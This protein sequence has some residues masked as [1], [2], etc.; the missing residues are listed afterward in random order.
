M[1][2]SFLTSL[3]SLF[4]VMLVQAQVTE[5]EVTVT[6]EE[7]ASAVLNAIGGNDAAATITKLKVSG[8]INSYDFMIMRNKMP[9]LSELDLGDARVVYNAY[10]HYENYHSEND[11]FPAYAF[12]RCKNLTK[13]VLPRNIT[14]IGNYA[15][16]DCSSLKEVVFSEGL[17]QINGFAFDRC[18]LQDE[19]CFPS[20]LKSI[21]DCAFQYNKSLSSVKFAEGLEYLGRSVFYN[22]PKLIEV[23]FPTSL[24]TVGETAF[25]NTAIKDVYTY[26]ISPLSINQNT[27]SQSVFQEATLHVP[28]TAENNYYWDTQWSQFLSM[29]TFNEPYDYFY[30]ADDLIIKGDTPTLD[31]NKDPEKGE[32]KDP[33]ADLEP[34]SGLVVEGDD[35][36]QDLNDVH[37]KDDGN[38]N[39]G[40]II[41]QGD[42]KGNGNIHAKNVHIDIEVQANR[43]YF[44]CFPY[45]I[46]KTNIK[47]K[48]QYVLR[49]Y[50]GDARAQNGSGGWKD[51]VDDHLTAGIGYI[52]Q[53]SVSGTLTFQIPDITFDNQNRDLPLDSHEADAAQD[54]GWNFI[55]NPFTSYFDMCAL[56]YDYPITI[57][58]GTTYEALNPQDDEYVL[59]PYQAFFVQKPNTVDEVTFNAAE[60]KTKIQSEAAQ[61]ASIRMRVAKRASNVE[62]SLINLTLSDGETSDKT[63]VVFNARRRATYETECDA[64]KFMADGTPQ[65]YSLD[66]QG[67]KYAIN[68]RPAGNGIVTLGYN[69][70]KAGSY[71]IDLSRA[72]VGVMLKD[73][74]T[75]ASHDF[76]KGGY[77]FTTEAGAFENRF[78]L[79][80]SHDVTGVNGVF[81]A[82]KAVVDVENGTLTVSRADGL[83]TS[84]TSASGIA[85]GTITG[86]GSMRLQ[87][88]IYVVT[89]GNVSQK[90]MVK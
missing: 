8:T 33:D 16:Y 82:G 50:D 37:I 62:R 44:F 76:S 51:V 70:A 21:T 18:D 69:A 22:D 11:V 87:P 2:K 67:V 73:K 68:E 27:F 47:Y 77:T 45:N 55:G 28:E 34:G 17:E 24:R 84:V 43:W 15:F 3:F 9:N 71:T 89:V 52:F 65:L 39:G 12:Y 49:L 41:G 86:N 85:V 19:I 36:N 26:V 10:C 90:I 66:E 57:W 23:R 61:E 79:V 4:C 13:C 83:T 25:Y 75:G 56:G 46:N 74:T 5:M 81:A 72:D 54:A 31:G 20:T 40:S 80:K 53:G 88:G 32:V 48:G 60:R 6:A 35:K 58:N 1:K 29:T 30:L 14:R 78:L 63:R 7:N 38:G 59:H 64:A 42:G